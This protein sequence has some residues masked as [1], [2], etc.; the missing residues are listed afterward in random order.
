VPPALLE[1]SFI[2]LLNTPTYT[3]TEEST[4][5]AIG[6]QK[7][8]KKKPKNHLNPAP[9]NDDNT[10]DSMTDGFFPYGILFYCLALGLLLGLM[11][12]AICN[13]KIWKI[14]VDSTPSHFFRG[15]TSDGITLDTLT[16]GNYS[17]YDSLSMNDLEGGVENYYESAL[18]S[19]RIES[20]HSIKL[21]EP[22]EIVLIKV[23]GEGNFGRVW[24]GRWRVT[25]VAVKEFVFAQTAVTGK[26]KLKKEIIEEIVGEAAIMSILRHPRITILHGVSLTSQAIWIVSELCTKG[27]LRSLL[28]KEGEILATKTK[29]RLAIDIAEGMV[30]LH[31]RDPAIIHRD[32]KSHNIFVHSSYS[33]FDEM[34]FIAK[35]GDWGS[36]RAALA[37]SR[38]M[39]QGVGTAC[40]LAPEVIKHSQNTAA[41][42]VYS[43]AIILWELFSNVEVYH[44]LTSVQIVAGVANDNLRPPPI[45]SPVTDLMERCWLENPEQRP[46][47]VEIKEE[48][49]LLIMASDLD[50]ALT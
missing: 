26:S 20:E 6:F 43:Y 22:K 47:F 2:S 44:N 15:A 13:D 24:R 30:Y 40:W 49:K 4:V 12:S 10:R 7:K 32:L 16:F 34:N 11:L 48:L 1:F 42:D 27:S 33:E 29:L 50:L 9:E 36:A 38:T 3:L 5:Y 23:I 39:T 35:I 37:G 8:P 25:N 31:S 19:R 46:T 18:H 41:S 28:D 45:L 17:G 14:V 21:I